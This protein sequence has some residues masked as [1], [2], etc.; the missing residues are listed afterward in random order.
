MILIAPSAVIGLVAAIGFPWPA[1]AGDAPAWRQPLP[2]TAAI[3]GDD[4]G[5]EDQA[6]V[7]DTIAHWR[8]MLA[9]PFPDAADGCARYPRGLAVVIEGVAFDP[10]SDTIPSTTM[11]LPLVNIRIPAKRVQGYVE[12]AGGIHPVIPP[13]MLVHLKADSTIRLA[14]AQDFEMDDGP[15]LGGQATAKVL[16]YD[17]ST[18]ERD[19]Y[20]TVLDGSLAGQFGWV[21]SSEAHGDDGKPID[22]FAGSVIEVPRRAPPTAAPATPQETRE[23]QGEKG[24]EIIFAQMPGLSSAECSLV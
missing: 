4:G 15:D 5:G 19:L 6:T 7:C 11:G 14:P 2:G 16:R 24:W 9:A 3:L 17:P 1:V 23:W 22:M 21:F 18:G 10:A 12:M 20:V 13:G 8:A